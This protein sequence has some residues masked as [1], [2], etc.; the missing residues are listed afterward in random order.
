MLPGQGYQVYLKTAETLIYPSGGLAKP[1][2]IQLTEPTHFQFTVETGENAT[3]VVTTDVNPRLSDGTPLEINDEIGVFTSDGRCCGAIVW[4]GKNSAISVWGDNSQTSNI[5]GFAAEDTFRYRIWRKSDNTEYLATSDYQVNHP[6]V[7]RS[8]GFS[9]LTS[10]I[11]NLT[12]DVTAF[13]GTKCPTDFQL[14]QNFPNPFNPET[15]IE[16]DIPHKSYV[17]LTIYD[18]Q[19]RYIRTLLQGEKAAGHYNFTW[20]SRDEIGKLAPNGVYIYQLVSDS[21]TFSKKMILLK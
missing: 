19:G 12:T 21:Y 6:V 1:K 17:R 9:V 11:A 18:I 8:N 7:Y 13:D 3:I 20:D 4:E 15:H 2:P 5:D 14:F 16:F 10:L